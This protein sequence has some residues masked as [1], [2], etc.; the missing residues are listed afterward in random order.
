MPLSFA[1]VNGLVAA[2][3]TAEVRATVDPSDLNVPG[4]WVTV[5][6]I[7]AANLAGSVTLLCAIYLVAPD[8]D[9]Q[10]AMDALAEMYNKTVPGV[11]TP[12]GPV[13]PQGIILPD[14]TT[15]LPALRVPVNLQESDYA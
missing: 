15:A 9:Y 7:Q 1:P 2:L 11:L 10:R 6:G 3:N 13:V 8:Q 14:T 4:A 5:E 12:D